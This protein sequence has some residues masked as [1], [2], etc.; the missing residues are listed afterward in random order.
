MALRG[1]TRLEQAGA[2]WSWLEQEA[3]E[4][5][6]RSRRA[7]AGAGSSSYRAGLLLLLGCL[8]AGVG[9]PAA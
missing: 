2:G 6:G 9:W 5:A 1:L 3:A 8:R 4:G 7:Q